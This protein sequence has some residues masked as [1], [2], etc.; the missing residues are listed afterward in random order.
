MRRPITD[1]LRD[2]ETLDVPVPTGLADNVWR[3][4]GLDP[5]SAE[6]RPG[7]DE[8]ASRRR[9]R[10]PTRRWLLLA[11]AAAVVVVVAS[12]TLVLVP[13]PDSAL[14]VL[15][16]ARRRFRSPPSLSMEVVRTAS[17]ATLA[18]E[19]PGDRQ[20]TSDWVQVTAVEYQ[21]DT[22]WWTEIAADDA[23][24]F[25]TGTVGRFSVS[26]GTYMGSYNPVSKLLRVEPLSPRDA[27]PGEP[28]Y[29]V[30]PEL[31]EGPALDEESIAKRC[32]LEDDDV[33]AGRPARHIRCDLEGR[34]PSAGL[35]PGDVA[36]VWLDAE[37]GLVLR[38]KFPDGGGHEVRRITYGVDHPD[39]RFE[40]TPPE[41]GTVL[42]AGADEA[43]ERFRSP[44][45]P[46]VASTSVEPDRPG[47][48]IVTP[49]AA[50]VALSPGSDRDL[51]N[52]QLAELDPVTGV[53][54]RRIPVPPV[55]T[56]LE[57]GKSRDVATIS[58]LELVGHI[59]YGLD[60]LAGAVHRFDTRTGAFLGEPIIVRAP[61]TTAARLV[62]AG[63]DVWLATHYA[64][65]VA[66]GATEAGS[67]H[68]LDA[69]GAIAQ[70]VDL[71]GGP[72][73]GA[74][75]AH[76]SIW[77][78]VAEPPPTPQ[79]SLVGALYRIDPSAGTIIGRVLTHAPGELVAT[80]DS[81]WVAGQIA[82]R[83]DVGTGRI[84]ASLDLTEGSGTG[85]LASA[86]DGRVF[87]ADGEGTTVSE[88]D[89]TTNGIVARYEVG[90]APNALF[91]DGDQL[92]VSVQG[93]RAVVRITP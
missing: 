48:I 50:W 79:G 53:L 93:A 7:A 2:L 59:L 4:L 44:I 39:G 84:T 21:D 26:D 33:V 92:W 20:P 43:P 23:N 88:V 72:Y 62:V 85:A 47:A 32:T 11:A 29:L 15:D 78:S 51:G 41:G 76:G 90:A 54:R 36:D 42:W 46:G 31:H 10:P 65:P 28:L 14:A 6:D 17:Q 12:A 63:S 45:P 30:S 1:V 24:P 49:T 61:G 91:T 56:T 18:E 74:I 35:Q 13:T 16:E 25:E 3:R 80:P 82:E 81:I 73:G 83:I 69:D 9:T 22:H 52:G 67:L 5:D 71:G 86:A 19:L 57:G 64:R 70:T 89:P 58:D 75:F 87:I 27:S 40:V 38:M 8:L 77:I 34:A 37:T 55:A 66:G 68:R 60:T